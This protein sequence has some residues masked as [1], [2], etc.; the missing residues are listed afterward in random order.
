MAETIEKTVSQGATGRVVRI[1]GAVV[2]VEFPPDQMPAIYNALPPLTQRPRRG[3][4]ARCLRCRRTFRAT[5][6]RTVAMSSTDGM[7]R[8]IEAVDTGSPIKMP[9][10]PETLGPHLER[11]GRA[12]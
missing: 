11:H 4:S 2:D 7:V 12:G 5:S 8:G 1:V 6:S 3:R 10:G 9:V